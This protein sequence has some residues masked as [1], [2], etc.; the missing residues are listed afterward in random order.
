MPNL[1]HAGTEK[2]PEIACRDDGFISLKGR[3]LPED[4]AAFYAP[5]IEWL[6]DYYREPQ[7]ETM[8]HI[9]LEYMNSASASMLHKMCFALE[10]LVKYRNRF[11]QS[12]EIPVQWALP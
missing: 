1:Y 7:P 9:D 11:N 3:S 5:M 8:V 4:P 12:L 6:S 2:T 10:R